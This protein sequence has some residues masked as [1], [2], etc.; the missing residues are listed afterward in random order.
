MARG[1]RRLLEKMGVHSIPQSIAVPFLAGQRCCISARSSHH[2]TRTTTVL[3]AQK[4]NKRKTKERLA[5]ADA[6]VRVVIHP[7]YD[8]RVR[9]LCSGLYPGHRAMILKRISLSTCVAENVMPEARKVHT[10]Q[11]YVCTMPCRD[12]M[13]VEGFRTAGTALLQFE[14]HPIGN[15]STAI[16][17]YSYV[18]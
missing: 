2:S 16:S 9:C 7:G 5:S 12:C 6:L 8:S 3:Q 1:N 10:H 14:T 17:S 15:S 4:V 18:R 13:S 11:T